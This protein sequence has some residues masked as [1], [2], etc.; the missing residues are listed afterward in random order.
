MVV[1]DEHFKNVYVP[2]TATK[3]AGRLVVALSPLIKAKRK[4]R[5]K[6]G[7]KIGIKTD[8]KCIFKHA[9]EVKIQVIVGKH[10][11]G[12]IWPCRGSAYK[13]SLMK[14]QSAGIR[15]CAPLKVKLPLVPGLRIYSK[16]KMTVD[17]CSFTKS[18]ESDLGKS[19]VFCEAV[20]AIEI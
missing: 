5:S 15:N 10:M 1:S 17:Y 9:L 12:T 13:E 2:R 16:E 4:G 7:I 18:D 20:V 19:K 6:I 3:L 11:F 14:V 8:L